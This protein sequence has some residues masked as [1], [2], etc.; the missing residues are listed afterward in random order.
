MLVSDFNFVLPEAQ[1]AQVPIPERTASRLLT[2]DRVTGGIREGHVA[3]L[4]AILRPGDVV[5]LNNTRV[6]RA[7]LLGHRTPS[8]GAVECLLLGHL[9]NDHWDAL[10]HPGQKLRVGERCQFRG[11]G[12]EVFA[13]ILERHFHGRRTIRLWTPGGG[14]LVAA[15][16]AIGQV[17]LPP[18]VKRSANEDDAERYQTVYARHRGSVA[19]PTAGLHFSEEL[20]EELVCR[21]IERVEITLHVQYGTFKPVR[22]DRVEEHAI[23]TEQFEISKVAAQ[24]INRALMEKRRVVAI[25][26]TTTRALETTA[27]DSSEGR[28][29][30]GC[31]STDLYIYPGF[32]FQAVGALMTNFHLPCSSL[33]MLTCAFGGQKHVLEAYRHAVEHGYRFYSY[34]DAMLIL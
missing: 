28:V 24:K 29:Y 2:L 34:G 15:L 23:D 33:L 14:D 11:G 18:Y 16:D 1:I 7:R 4:P 12:H 31:T 8:G 25:G 17:P 20:L 3:D 26:T 27:L 5:V 32:K 21:G 10:L 6:F 13:E 19:A 9:G 30:S 22:V